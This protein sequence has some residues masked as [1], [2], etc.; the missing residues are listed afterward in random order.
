MSENSEPP[1]PPSADSAAEW[2]RVLGLP[3]AGLVLGWMLQQLGIF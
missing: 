1:V 3:A 2:C